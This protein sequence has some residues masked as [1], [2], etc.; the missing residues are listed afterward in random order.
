MSTETR[1]LAAILFSDICGYSRI[2]GS[3]EEQAL[4]IV[5][6]HNNC[7]GQATKV[8]GGRII[9]TMG[10]GV[11][12]EFTSAV[13][14][15]QAA[16]DVQKAVAEHNAHAP[17]RE[18]FQLRIGIHVG[19]VVV[20]EGGD[21]FGDGVNVASRIQPLAEPG[22]ICVS[23]DI[24][25]LVNNKISIQAVNLG[26]HELRN[27]SRQIDIYEILVD[28]VARG[29]KTAEQAHDAGRGLR[30]VW[31]GAAAILAAAVLAGGFM[32]VRNVRFKRSAERFFSDT[33]AKAAELAGKGDLA[34]A[35]AALEAY[36][37]I[38]RQTEWQSKIDAEKDRLE[39]QQKHGMRMMEAERVYNRTTARA[40]ERLEQG[41]VAGAIAV[42]N[43]YPVI[44]AQTEWQDKIN[45]EKKRLEE[46][47]MHESRTKR[48]KE[49]LAAV[50]NNDRQAALAVV[51]PDILRNADRDALWMRL[52]AMVDIWK[53]TP[54]LEWDAERKEWFI[55]PDPPR[56]PSRAWGQP[57]M[58]KPPRMQPDGARP[59]VNPAG[60][61]R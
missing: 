56:E 10:D 53:D 36:P 7:I 4:A 19:D 13:N 8:H 44:Y 14:A 26:P 47:L 34:A 16:M 48:Q 55:H 12:A 1:R 18:K 51:H 11:L 41:D 29:K 39:K 6:M 57:P 50:Q 52:K 32:F 15:V 42:L 59:P 54:A 45:A 38:F 23:R 43:V 22:G 2:M 49:F 27:I 61:L 35:I 31:L 20:A 9:K 5:S 40:A 17:D 37:A 30:C 58:R 28:A 24:F 60:Q 33:S 46:R 21:L 25:D 3:D